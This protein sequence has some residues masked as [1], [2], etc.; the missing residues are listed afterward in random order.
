ML[1]QLQ[2]WLG[3]KKR[4][5]AL[6][7]ALF[8][9]LAS[10][11]FKAKYQAF[12]ESVEDPEPHDIHFTMLINKLST[13]ERNM[14]L[15][16]DAYKDVAPINMDVD[17]KGTTDSPPAPFTL[18][19]Q[20]QIDANIAAFDA[21]ALSED[22]QATYKRI[23]EIVPLMASIHGELDDETMSDEE[24]QALA[25][26]LVELSE[27]KAE[28]WKILD[29]KAGTEGADQ[30]GDKEKEITLQ[31]LKTRLNRVTENIKRTNT[32]IETAIASGKKN[33]EDNARKRLVEYQA[34]R[35]TL[36]A[37]IAALDEQK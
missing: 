19:D 18:P 13:I 7:L 11:E 29:G 20:T 15:N 5:Y 4:K 34:E 17:G 21:T 36:E 31:G 2:N 8:I 6:G 1:E 24:R 32:S 9:A 30:T 25:E 27:E 26:E 22:K 28:L 12:L 23:Q 37:E 16:P 3:D 33:V 35:E 10:I 14:L